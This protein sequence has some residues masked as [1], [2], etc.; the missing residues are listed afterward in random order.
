MNFDNNVLTD[1]PNV[2]SEVWLCDLTYTQQTI[3]S[4]T[5]PMAVAGIATYTEKHLPTVNNI[6]IFSDTRKR[7]VT[8]IV[9][10][11]RLDEQG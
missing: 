5:I 2:Q 8:A 11:F 4:D 10:I 7:E 9:N 6:K 1:S 3:A